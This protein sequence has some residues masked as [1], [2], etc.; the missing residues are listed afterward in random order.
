MFRSVRPVP[1]RALRQR[2][3]NE[4]PKR[5]LGFAATTATTTTAA[6]PLAAASAA[7]ADLLLAQTG[8]GRPRP[9][10]CQSS[11]PASKRR[12]QDGTHQ[13]AQVSSSLKLVNSMTEFIDL[14]ELVQSWYV[15]ERN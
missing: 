1:A 15:P 14:F 11:S 6:T 7:D 3:V 10:D 13:F 12:C 9:Q 5:L 2:R 8:G 4:T